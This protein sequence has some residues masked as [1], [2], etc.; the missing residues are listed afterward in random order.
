MKIDLYFTGMML[1]RRI[2]WTAS[3]NYTA[4]PKMNVDALDS[5][6]NTEYLIYSVYY[7]E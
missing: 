1:V 3:A 5:L 4:T 7:S 6:F 2:A